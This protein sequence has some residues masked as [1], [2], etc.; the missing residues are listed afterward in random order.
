MMKYIRSTIY[1]P[2]IMMVGKLNIVKCCVYA[3]YTR[4]TALR[5]HTGYRLFLGSVSLYSMSKRQNINSRISAEAELIG[6]DGVI[7]GFLWSR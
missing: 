7:P 2:L 4:H 1:M 5:P 3:S 6:A